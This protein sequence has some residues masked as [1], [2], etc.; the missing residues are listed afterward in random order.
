LFWANGPTRDLDHQQ[1][2]SKNLGEKNMK[3]V[4]TVLKAVALAMGVAVIVL[5]IIGVLSTG[6]AISLLGIGLTALGIAAF[7]K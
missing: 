4:S 6:T 1:D 7:Q 5:G 2:I 3:I